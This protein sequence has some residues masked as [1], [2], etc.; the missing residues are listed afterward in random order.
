MH[1]DIK[2]ANL[3][4]TADL[5]TVK[6]GHF[7][8]C[9]PVRAL[10]AGHNARDMAGTFLHMAPEVFNATASYS[11]K[12]DIFSAAVCMVHLISG[13]HAYAADPD[14]LQPELLA[15]RVC[16]SPSLFRFLSLF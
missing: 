15:R 7:G 6:L 14:L 10:Q 5:E 8:L 9:L 3:L 2:A 1:R 16:L 4:C 11:E 12:A 13:E